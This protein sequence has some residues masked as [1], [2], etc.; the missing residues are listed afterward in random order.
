MSM[1]GASWTWRYLQVVGADRDPPQRHKRQVAGEQPL[2]D[3]AEHRLVGLDVDV[4]VLELADLVAVGRRGGS[5]VRAQFLALVCDTAPDAQ[6]PTSPP[7]LSSGRRR[8]RDACGHERDEGQWAAGRLQLMRL[9]EPGEWAGIRHMLRPVHPPRG[10]VYDKGLQ[11]AR[12]MAAGGWR[13]FSVPSSPPSW[14]ARS[15][16]TFN[17]WPERGERPKIGM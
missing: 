15:P 17:L 9:A 14:T 1:L 4:D 7:Q 10:H 8:R 11:E 16:P 2:L 6:G 5:R 13:V 12:P 3:R